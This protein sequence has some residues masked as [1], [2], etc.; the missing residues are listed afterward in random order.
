MLKIDQRTTRAMNRRLVLNLLRREGSLSR[1]EIAEITGLSRATVT[2]VVSD[3][4]AENYLVEGETVRGAGGRRPI[5]LAINY[6]GHLAIGIKMNVG[7]LECILTDLSTEPIS[8]VAVTFSDPAPEA[9]LNAAETAIRHL[10]EVAPKDAGPVTGIGFSMPGT[11]D[12]ESG[13]C[14][15]S[16]RFL[17]DNVPFSDMLYR[18]VQIPVWMEDDTI[19]FAL[20]QHLFGLGRQC[21]TFGALAIGVGIGCAAVSNG[22]VLRGAHGQAGK[23]GHTI[24]RLDGALCEC[25]RRGCL[26][27]Y[28]SEP[29]LVARWRTEKGLG[30]Q[31]DRFS[32]KDAALQGEPAARAIL[33]EAG[34]NIGMHLAAFANIVDPEIIV[35][36]GEAVCF[37]DL[38]FGP[39]RESLKVYCLSTP[40]AILPDERENF[41]SSGAAAL[42]TQRLFNFETEPGSQ[43]ADPA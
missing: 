23:L 15:K 34:E 10:M 7:S 37:G 8:S 20:A 39:M 16:H 13:I 36:G 21:N 12:I 9:V 17:W 25:G 31:H 3:L 30:P 4:I 1:V 11:I 14:I 28:Y 40:P 35:V 5:P 2:F 42:A 27:A 33:S 22:V 19:A 18:R 6:G 43:Q 29:A 41:W 38:L 24:H 32:M 26:Q